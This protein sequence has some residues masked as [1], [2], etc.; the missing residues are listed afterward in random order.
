M[1]QTATT[2]RYKKAI[3]QVLN[4]KGKIDHEIPVLFNPT[5]YALEKSNEFA[6]I[7]IPGLE[8]PLLQFVRG[9]LATLNMDLFFDSYEEGK[10]VREYTG[11][12]ANLLKID[13]ELHAP[14]ILR[15]A[16]ANLS[17]TAVLTRVSQK[18]TMFM[19]DGIPVRATLGVSFSEY[20]TQLSGKEEIK[21]SRDRTRTRIVKQGDT[22]WQIAES[23]YG[24][25]ALWRAIAAANSIRCPRKL[26]PGTEILIPPLETGAAP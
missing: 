2:S 1:A 11:K 14:P 9:G 20:R 16:W 4:G 12:I 24:D 22:L 26:K 21:H 19:A 10:D 15:F 8:S 25:P 5:E 6:N 3:I 23:Q 7:N 18:F 13:R 17:F